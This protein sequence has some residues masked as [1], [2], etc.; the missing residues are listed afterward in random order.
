MFQTTSAMFQALGDTWIRDVQRPFYGRDVLGNALNASY[1]TATIISQV[2][3][4][5]S[6]ITY[7]RF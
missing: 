1:F 5:P 6:H 7:H 3:L 2:G 4:S